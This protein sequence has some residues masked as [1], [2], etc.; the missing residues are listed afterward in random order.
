MGGTMFAGVAT[1]EI[2][3]EA[4]SIS[5]EEEPDGKTILQIYDPA[6][7]TLSRYYWNLK[8][9]GQGEPIEGENGYEGCW[10]DFYA[11]PLTEFPTL[12]PGQGYWLTISEFNE[13][14]KITIAGAVFTT[15]TESSTVALPVV[16]DVKDMHSN[17]MPG[18]ALTLDQ[19]YIEGEEEPDGK[20]I[21]QLYNPEDNTLTRYYW[22]LKLDGQGEPIEI[23]T[24]YEGCW[25]DFYAD[26]LTE[27]PTIV[28]GRGF[29]LT[30]SE[31]GVDSMMRVPNPL[32]IEK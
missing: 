18:N 8:L 4:F 21:L 2:S 29:W 25:C 19:I 27:F 17:P 14:P 6:H 24:G 12:K 5:G 10:C 3:L 23:E 7:N 30:V 20:T 32:Y 15:D 16:P 28:A 26:P 11:D 31:F 9:D 1:D 22:N 13:D